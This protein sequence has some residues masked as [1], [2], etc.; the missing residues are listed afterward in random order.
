MR[1]AHLIRSIVEGTHPAYAE[2]ERVI[3]F[4]WR[5]LLEDQEPPPDTVALDHSWRD[6]WDSARGVYVL[7]GM[8]A[9]WVDLKRSEVPA[10]FTT[11]HPKPPWESRE[12]A[13][14]Y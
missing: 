3:M 9:D 6:Q 7:Q 5:K 13:S 8:K 11:K 2:T 10:V 1:G 12:V 4:R 14:I